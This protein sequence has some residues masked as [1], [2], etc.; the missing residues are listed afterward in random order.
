MNSYC[1]NIHGYCNNYRYLYYF[2]LTDL[3]ILNFKV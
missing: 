2:N 1:V 3:V